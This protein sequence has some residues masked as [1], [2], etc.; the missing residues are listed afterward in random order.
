MLLD[1]G[2]ATSRPT[3]TGGEEG[4][5]LARAWPR[6]AP[7]CTGTPVG[8]RSGFSTGVSSLREVG[9]GGGLRRP[10]PQ[11]QAAWVE[12]SEIPGA[13]SVVLKGWTLTLA[14]GLPALWFL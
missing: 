10:W 11:V 1:P 8:R 5:F 3:L 13:W 2:E 14:P 6:P 7:A 4:P 12:N 9:P